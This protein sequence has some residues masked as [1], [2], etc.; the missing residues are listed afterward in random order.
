M[1]CQSFLFLIGAWMFHLRCFNLGA[2][3]C[4]QKYFK[5]LRFSNESL[6]IKVSDTG[7]PSHE[8]EPTLTTRRLLKSVEAQSPPVGIASY[9]GEGMP[10]QEILLHSLDRGSNDEVG[11]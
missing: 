6:V 9:F 2:Q 7:P 10:A 5:K 4:A 8:F 1:I 3:E 11:R